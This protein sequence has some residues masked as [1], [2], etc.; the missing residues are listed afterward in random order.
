MYAFKRTYDIPTYLYIKHSKWSIFCQR[1]PK[2]T[3]KTQEKVDFWW[4]VGRFYQMP[5]IFTIGMKKVTWNFANLFLSSSL[6]TLY[7]LSFYLL[8]FYLLSFYLL[9]FYLLPFY[10]LSFYLLCLFSS[11]WHF[12]HNFKNIH[13]QSICRYLPSLFLFILFQA[14]ILISTDTDS[15]YKYVIAAGYFWHIDS[16]NLNLNFSLQGDRTRSKFPLKGL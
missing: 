14:P 15:P 2:K 8:S 5:T 1:L 3:S 7:I 4:V 16:A 9:Y 13:P 12:A 6:F 11:T 10:L